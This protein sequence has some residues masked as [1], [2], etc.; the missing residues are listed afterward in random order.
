MLRTLLLVIT[1][2]V[3][4][5]AVATAAP[6]QKAA[7]RVVV[8][9]K[10]I[11]LL[12]QVYFELGKP[13]IK[14]ESYAILDALVA[15]LKTDKRI[16]LVEI[17]GHTDARGNDAYNLEISEQRAQAILQYL[18]DKGV[19]AKRLRAKGYGETKPLDKAAN[20]KAWAKNRRMAFVILQRITT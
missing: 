20:A 18:V 6:D 11:E 8:T 7:K 16:G 15:T 12:D 19:D 17:Q 9:T 2:V 5:G 14:A 4:Q 10:T 13:V 3:W 1:V